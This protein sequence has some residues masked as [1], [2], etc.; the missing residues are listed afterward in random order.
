MPIDEPQSSDAA[1]S[2]PSCADAVRGGDQ[3]AKGTNLVVQS[4]SKRK[5]PDGRRSRNPVEVF[6]LLYIHVKWNAS[7]Q[8]FSQLNFC[9]QLWREVDVATI[10]G[11]HV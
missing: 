1:S 9:P 8:N 4:R 7:R 11:L 10:A 6:A 5:I 2:N 3:N